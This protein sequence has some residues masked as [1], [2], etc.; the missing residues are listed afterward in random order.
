M[1]LIYLLFFIFLNLRQFH[2]FSLFTAYI[3]LKESTFDVE[4]K[5]FKI[6]TL[7]L[8]SDLWF[9]ILDY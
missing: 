4:I 8:S 1:D 3:F 6:T 9:T 7:H 5:R 2:F